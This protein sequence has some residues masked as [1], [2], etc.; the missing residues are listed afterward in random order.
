M[1]RRP[2]LATAAVLVAAAC[3]LSMLAVGAIA[4]SR[5]VTKLSTPILISG[6]DLGFRV[7][8][9]QGGTPVGR[10]VIRVDGRWVEPK[11]VPEP[12]RLASR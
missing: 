11:S 3:L 10:V 4:Q 7:E 8:G 1:L 2:V 12:L 9:Y 6:S 5:E